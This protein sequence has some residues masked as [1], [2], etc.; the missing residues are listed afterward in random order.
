[1]KSEYGR[2]WKEAILANFKVWL[3][4]HSGEI[5]KRLEKEI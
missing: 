5:E 1:V 4:Q 3:Q 2:I